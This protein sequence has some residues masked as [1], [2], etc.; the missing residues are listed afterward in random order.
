MTR[1]VRG[2]PSSS[3]AM[4]C[5]AFFRKFLH[6]AG[7]SLLGEHPH[8]RIRT[9]QFLLAAVLM[10][11]CI[12]VVYFMRAAGIGG[13]GDIDT[14]AIL[15]SAGLVVIYAVIRSGL[16][17]HMKDPSLAFFQML[18]AVACNAAAFVITG[19]GRGV[20]LPILSVVL[21]F[22]MFGLSMRQVVSV[23]IY[24]LALF[25][26]AEV[27]ELHR[28]G[29]EESAGLLGAYLFMLLV[30]LFAT[31]FLTWRL[32]QMSAHMRKQKNELATALEKIQEIATRDE[33]TGIANRRFM[34][35]KMRE[36][37]Q[38]TQRVSS[39]LLLAMLDID[40]FKRIN[41][42][43]GHQEGDRALQVFTSVVQNTIRTND[44]LA[45]WGGEE[46]VILLTDT[47]VSVGEICLERV[48]AKVADIAIPGGDGGTRLTVSIGATQYQ[49]GEPIETA[50]A[51]ADAALYDAKS[52]GRNQVVWVL[53][54]ASNG[55]PVAE[56]T[57]AAPVVSK[58]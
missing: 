50:L 3:A 22:G 28:P 6:R 24:G 30:V 7:N 47:E 52:Q 48:R 38:R 54:R 23:A 17:L 1:H 57:D 20:T 18:Y 25:G 2:H 56:L 36:E 5:A 58:P 43:Y 45:R 19:Q 14:W 35:E 31:T 51:R 40:Y 32:Q 9:T 29:T 27:Y 11:A 8:M 53:G 15:C 37:V 16:S 33:L 49:Q 39:P 34:Q 46:F 4:G 13:M 44:T 42:R 10:L 26:A 21:M 55:A 12:G 41:D